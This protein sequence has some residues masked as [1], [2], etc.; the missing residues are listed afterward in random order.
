MVNRLVKSVSNGP[1][2]RVCRV[3]RR[4]AMIYVRFVSKI[5]FPSE[6]VVVG[7]RSNRLDRESR[8]AMEEE[9]R[10]SFFSVDEETNLRCRFG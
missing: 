6:E 8:E 1:A 2:K 10:K 5:V 9:K 3:V 4:S 7:S